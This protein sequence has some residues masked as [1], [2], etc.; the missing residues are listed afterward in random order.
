MGTPILHTKKF[1][2]INGK[3]KLIP[4]DYKPP[5]ELPDLNYPL[6]LTTGRSLYQYHTGT[7]SGKVTGLNTLYGHEIIEI[8]PDDASF[9][10]ISNGDIVQVTSRRG[11]VK[12]QARVTESTPKGLVAMTFHFAESPTNVLTNP[13]VDTS[14]WNS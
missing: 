7:I 8:N 6:I 4:L 10:E 12:A 13:E 11:E 2:T 5:L 9:L 1:N 3:G 14:I